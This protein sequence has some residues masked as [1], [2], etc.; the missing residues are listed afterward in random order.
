VLTGWLHGGHPG[1][2]FLLGRL[3]GTMLTSDVLKN[4]FIRVF[5]KSKWRVVRGY[6][7][8]RHSFA[9]NLARAGIDQRVIDELMGHS[10]EAMRKRYRHLFL[11]QRRTA[12]H[13]L[14][15]APATGG[16]VVAPPA[17]VSRFG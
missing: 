12:V 10:T 17:I 8:L 9:S 5:R 13:A 2:Q 15:G 1:G 14:F 4:V 16:T 3:P 6:H 11:D 7:V